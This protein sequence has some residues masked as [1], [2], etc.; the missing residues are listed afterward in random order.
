M[1]EINFIDLI[2]QQQKIRPQIDAAI[3]KVLDHGQFIMG[4]EIFELEDRLARYVGVKHCVSTSSGTDALLMALMALGVGVGDA[5]FTTPFTFVSTTEVISLLGATPVFVD[6]DP[7]TFNIDP[8]KL[9]A[10]IK[11]IELR[12]SVTKPLTPCGIIPVDLFGLPADYDSINA[13]A[14]EYNLFVLEDAAQSFGGVYKGRR[15]GSLAEIAATSFFPAKPLGCYGDGGAIF[16]DN[17]DLADILSSIRMHG[18][19]KDRYENVRTGVNGRMDTIQA[20]V[21]LQK[22]EIFPNELLER[23]RVAARYSSL[24]SEVP[25][26]VPPYVPTDYRSAWAQYPVLLDNRESLQQIMSQKK[27]PVRVYYSKPLHLQSAYSAL[28]YH[29]GDLPFSENISERI[30]CLPMHPYLTDAEIE[31]VVSALRSDEMKR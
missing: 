6:I 21:L 13:L 18:M 28:G 31:Y 8:Q 2:A 24:L 3:K 20:A 22:F 14:T 16:T 1:D 26:I 7:Q 4:A 30:L 9:E 5:I 27:I 15:T 17:D 19:G 29:Y 10:A 11:D 12:S 23:Q 25:S